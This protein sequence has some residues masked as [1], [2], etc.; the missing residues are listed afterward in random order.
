MSNDNEDFSKHP[1]SLAEVRADKEADGRLWK[2]RDV[3]I[4]LLRDIDSGKLKPDVIVVVHKTTK[5]DASQSY[6]IGTASAGGT[7][8][9]ELVGILTEGRNC[10]LE[11]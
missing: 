6:A 3:L 2:P 4:S 1:M 11:D 10:I 5:D 7:G 9:H 8:R